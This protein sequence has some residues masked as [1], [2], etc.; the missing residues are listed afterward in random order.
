MKK[1][2]AIVVLVL[3]VSCSETNPNKSKKIEKCADYEY[4]K[5]DAIWGEKE[6]TKEKLSKATL[7]N[8]LK[9]SKYEEAFVQCENYLKENPQTFREKYLQ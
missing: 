4:L 8:K 9:A 7:K 6:A 1:L 3:L 2:L 5:W